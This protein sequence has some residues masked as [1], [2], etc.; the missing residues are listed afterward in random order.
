V[1]NKSKDSNE[2]TV[3]ASASF[4]TTLIRLWISSIHH[5]SVPNQ[6]Q[7]QSREN[8][9]FQPNSYLLAKS[10]EIHFH[11]AYELHLLNNFIF[12]WLL[13]NNFFLKFFS[14]QTQINKKKQGTGKIWRKEY[15]VSDYSFDELKSYTKLTRQL[16]KQINGNSYKIFQVT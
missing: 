6:M 15:M 11:P 10:S 5:V 9:L 2:L 12:K 16:L 7:T 1:I 8:E 3:I 14:S 4:K 13:L